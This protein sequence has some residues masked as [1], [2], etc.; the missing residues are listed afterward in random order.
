MQKAAIACTVLLLT[1]SL[2]ATACADP[3]SYR[4]KIIEFLSVV[5]ADSVLDQAMD[6]MMSSTL[7]ANPD[8]Q[9]YEPQIRS[10]MSKY[11]SM[12]SLREDVVSIY[13]QAFTE[14]E[15]QQILDFYETPI[16]R[17]A[18][19]QLPMIMREAAA[20]GAQRLQGHRSELADMIRKASAETDETPAAPD[21]APS[22]PAATPT[23]GPKLG[24]Y[25]YVEDLPEAIEKVPPDY[26]DSARATGV[27]GTVLVQALV[28]KDGAVKD[29][30]V[31][32]SIAGLDDSALRAVRQ[33]RFRPAQAK[34]KPVAVWVAIPVTFRLH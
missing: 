9:P 8:L 6:S 15:F 5:Q 14:N 33:W 17:K 30:R 12:D 32:K 3:T 2:A 23:D 13:E 19:R 1:A 22:P 24:E 7:R 21:T 28:G 16:G 25:V 26:P 27:Q 29:A 10:F 20:L 4:A 31:T 11:F 34:G 18:A